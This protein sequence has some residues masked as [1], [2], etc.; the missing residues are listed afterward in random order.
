MRYRIILSV[1]LL[2]A[3]GIALA[4]RLPEGVIPLHYTLSFSPDIPSAKF[5]GHEEIRVRLAKP[6][7]AITLNAADIEFHKVMVQSNEGR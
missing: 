5:D 6:M 4:Q 7:A 3:A 1:C 2:F